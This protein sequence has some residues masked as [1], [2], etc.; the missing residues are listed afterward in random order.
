LSEIVHI[1]PVA[2]SEFMKR[3][4]AIFITVIAFPGNN[5]CYVKRKRGALEKK[6]A[7]SQKCDTV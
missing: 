2:A 6:L 7:D 3:E 4:T 5:S 1:L